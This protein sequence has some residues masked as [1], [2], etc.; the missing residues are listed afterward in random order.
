MQLSKA[1]IV[2]FLTRCR[3]G[4]RHGIWRARFFLS[5]LLIVAILCGTLICVVSGG[6]ADVTSPY[7]LTPDHMEDL[8]P[9]IPFDCVL[10]LGAGL[11]PDGTPSEILADRVRTGCAVFLSDPE[12]FG[13]L[14]LSGDRTGDYDEV[15][16]M[17]SL[18]VSLGVPEDCILSDYE[19]Y[20]T[21]ESIS[22]ARN[23]FDIRCPLI[24]TQEYHLH[25]AVYIARALGMDAYGITADARPYAKRIFRESREALARFKDFFEAGRKK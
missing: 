1:K 6:V 21:F 2:A 8:P 25:R 17:R 13:N 5:F 19:G 24:I 18:A 7:M 4:I 10:I 20:S 16:A 15:T 9:D 3:C 23:H 11:R 22:R 12:R 14:L